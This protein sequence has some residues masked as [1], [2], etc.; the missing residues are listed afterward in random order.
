MQPQWIGCAPGN[1]SKGRPA[2]FRPEAIVIH[3]MVGTL[4]GT[5]SF[6]NDPRAK[7]SAHYGVGKQGEVH[8]YVDELDT[9]Y[10]AGIVVR[11][12]WEMIKPKVNPNFYT[13]GIE[14]EG[15]PEDTW[16]VPQLEASLELAAQIAHRWGIPIDRYHII[17]HREIRATKTCPGKIDLDAYVER[18]PTGAPKTV[19]FLR[20]VR[21]LAN[22]R[23]RRGKPSTSAPIVRV[24]PADT[25]VTVSGFTE[26]GERVEGSSFWY[27]DADGNYFWA[28]A[29]DV[30]TPAANIAA[31]A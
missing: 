9:A 30:P 6:F 17:G 4:R 15:Q 12:T 8:Q 31:G 7:V 24:L 25:L 5:D 27:R 29:T 18:I 26:A 14:H 13:I 19:L 2:S 21:V 11:P 23:L 20:S 16:P 1:F 22:L 28:G 3:I 10:H